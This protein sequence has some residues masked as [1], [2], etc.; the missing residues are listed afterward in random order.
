MQMA[1]DLDH[2]IENPGVDL[3]HGIARRPVRI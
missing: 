3:G 1:A 2:P